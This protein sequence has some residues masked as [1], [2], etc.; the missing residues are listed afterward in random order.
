MSY[1]TLKRSHGAYKGHFNRCLKRFN[2]LV[3]LT[4]PPTLSSVESAYTR[5]QKQLDSLITS[6][7][8]LTTFL[9]E[10]KF[11][12]GSNIDATKE[13]NEINTF[14]DTLIDEQAKVEVAYGAFKEKQKTDVPNGN[15]NTTTSASNTTHLHPTLSARP[16]V[17]LKALDPPAWNGVKADFYTWKNKFQHIMNEAQVSDELTQLCYIQ[18]DNILPKEYQLYVSD[19]SGISEVWSRLA[20]RVPKETIKYEVI[21]QFRSLQPLPIK[22]TP[23]MMRDFVNEISFFCRRMTDLGLTKDN[24]SCMVIQDV[25]EKLDEDTVRRYRSK[26]ELKRELGQNVDEDLHSIC[27]FIRA[28]ATT[29]ELSSGL[30]HSS[31]KKVYH[32]SK[33]DPG[34]QDKP[35]D[36]KPDDLKDKKPKCVLGCE[37]DHRLIDCDKY[38]KE[39]SID[40]KQQFLKDQFRCFA[41]LGRNHQARVCSRKDGQHCKVCNEY[42]HHWTLCKKTFELNAEA[43]AFLLKGSQ[44]IPTKENLAFSSTTPKDYSPLVLV[45]VSTREG[46]RRARCFLD[47]GSST[48]CIREAYARANGLQM[49]GICNISFGTAG[50]GRHDERGREY[51]L[52][53]RALGGT[54][55]YEIEASGLKTPCYD[56]Q[57]MSLNVFKQYEHLQEGKGKVYMEGGVVD[58]LMGRDYHPL[59]VSERIVRAKEDP[60]NKPSLAYTR[61]GCYIY[62]SLHRRSRKPTN[63]ILAMQSL[64]T[65]EDEEFKNFFYGEVLGVQP[66][67]RCVCS[68]NEIAESAFIKQVQE[69]TF[70]NEEGRV[71]MKIPWKPNFPDNLPNNFEAAKSD[72]LKREKK[73]IRDGTLEVHNKEVAELVERKVVRI[74]S[75]EETAVA[76][77]EPSWYLSHRVIEQSDSKT[78]K[79]RLVFDSARKFQNV[80]LN[81]GLEKG[82]NY[83]NSLFHC[84]LQWR[85]YPIAVC[86]DIRKFFNQ[87]VLSSQDQQ[88]HRFLW[89]GGDPSQPLKIYQWLRVLFGNKPSPDMATYA[90]RFLA[91][92][93]REELPLGAAKLTDTTY[94]D[95]V[96]YSEN[97]EEQASRVQGEVDIL[98]GKGNFTIKIWNSN[99]QLIDQN[100]DERWVEFLGHKWDKL[101]DVVQVKRGVVL[102]LDLSI[103]KKCMV[104]SIVAK[105]WDPFGY[106]LPV[107]IKLRIDLQ[108]LWQLG[109]DWEEELPEE[110]AEIWRSN[111]R[112]IEKLSN[113]VVERCLQPPNATGPPQL[114]AFSDGGN[115]AY[116]TCVFLRWPTS[117]GVK[118][119]FVAAKAF[120]APLKRK[121][122]PRLELMGAVA[123]GRLVTEV[124]R[125]LL[126]YELERSVFWIDSE[127]VLYW[128]NSS[129]F[130]FKPFVS[131]RIQEFQDSHPLWK[132]QV[133]HVPSNENPADCLTKPL[134]PE[135]L[136]PWHEGEYC[137]FLKEQEDNWPAEKTFFDLN[138]IKP[139]LEE[140]V[141]PLDPGLPKGK[142][143]PRVVTENV[144]RMVLNVQAENVDLDICQQLMVYF[145]TWGNIVRAVSHMQ[146]IFSS[147]N[148]KLELVHT[149]QTIKTAEITIYYICQAELRKDMTKTKQRFRKYNPV[150]D[151]NGLIRSKGRL[152]ETELSDE[153]KYPILLPGEY[154]A[155]RILAIHY[156]R[157]FLHQG[158]RVVIVNLLQLGLVIGGGKALLKSVADKCFFCRIR[159]RKLLQQQMAALPSF[160]IKV[161]EAPFASVAI[162]FFGNL[163]I[164]VSRN[165]SIN[166]A[167]MIVTCMTTRCIHLELCSLLDTNSFLQGWRRFVSSRGVHP[168][169]VFSDG[170]GAFIGAH[171]PLTQW[172]VE[173]DQC[174]ISREFPQTQFKFDWKFNVPTAS[175]MNGVVE[176]LINSVRKGLDA[177]I[178]NYTRSILTFENWSTVLSEVTYVI[179]SRPLFP[180]RDPWDF[181]CVTGNDILHPYGQPG[182]PK[183][184]QELGDCRKMFSV[185]QNKVASFWNAW[186]KNMP[187]QLIERSQWFRSRDNLQ[188]GDFV[189][190]LEPGLKRN[191]AP[192]SVWKKAIITGIHPSKDGLVRSVTL[193][194]SKRDEYVK[195]S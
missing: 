58:I 195:R 67:S 121:T 86:G 18:N 167:V 25:Y 83:T 186:L 60:D 46:W 82:P 57:P 55:E 124:S 93:Y 15:T 70:M 96:G 34:S 159:R 101:N 21:A 13:L 32:L 193:R 16:T 120:V 176:S 31:S 192:R 128:L 17:K 37:T 89:R 61:L 85:M 40:G 9:E 170:G 126:D 116:G 137:S 52:R 110:H 26:I 84:F 72:M 136:K 129:S 66:S 131:A 169:H 118:I 20:E 133:R 113:I 27:D 143:H 51:Q 88:F 171:H 6:T 175:H 141:Q 75:E 173:W 103:I 30:S 108:L 11:D 23:A 5:L 71:E 42:F 144:N 50:G 54:D 94:V 33:D 79:Y 187:P 45:E 189:L 177:A 174:L 44:E 165:A 56:V 98:L 65:A 164:K 53:I 36:Q 158:Y 105:I 155:L 76:E 39:L 74:L 47:E 59:I 49:T 2:T 48:S 114:H 92:K 24:Y 22:R 127:I 161:R 163:K 130:K 3:D 138:E 140:R 154:E 19:C 132:L 145:S 183:F 95:D 90:L 109:Y 153:V 181:H 80:S 152:V 125:T 185:A 172:I 35:G 135:R 43:E 64:R 73:D 117:T 68:D 122:V 151:G 14:H 156:H 146:Q 182:I 29:L 184:G 77:A 178:V 142:K 150:V 180:E 100:P 8:T 119:V 115:L 97:N 190:V 69:N 112:M 62:N 107:T 104:A 91:N 1:D 162:D 123:M 38:M 12:V 41:C 7:E 188:V 81:D 194:D 147:K 166:G 179:N 63:Q 168:N 99:S 106:W 149:P 102:V 148:I 134:S 28:E 87:V 4:P 111:V 10:G 78:T 139:F 157:Q 191:T 160:R